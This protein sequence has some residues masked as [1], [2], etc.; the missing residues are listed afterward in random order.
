MATA[1]G[2]TVR[3]I[4]VLRAIAATAVVY[5][6]CNPPGGGYGFPQ[7]GAWGVDIFFVISGFIIART[8]FKRPEGFMRS[9]IIRVVPI[10]LV[11]TVLTAVAVA[12]FPHRIN[13]TEVSPDGLL[14]SALFIPYEMATRPGPILEAGWTLSYEMFFYV[15]VALAL[16]ATG[17]AKRGL[18][19]AAVLLFLLVLSGWVS[20]SGWYLV[21][22]YQS[23][24]F[25]EFLSGILLWAAYERSRVNQGVFAGGRTSGAVTGVIMIAVGFTLLVAADTWDLFSAGF[26]ERF[27][28]YGVPSVLV[29]VGGLLTEPALS[30][31]R[32]MRLLVE[33]GDA[34]YAL[35]LFHPFVI[36]FLSR[37]AFDSV[38]PG[39]GLGLRVVMLLLAIV[40]A[41]VASVVVNRCVDGPIQ[42]RLRR[43]LLG[44]TSSG[45]VMSRV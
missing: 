45:K 10:Y 18:T 30:A 22:F 17:S 7:T 6:H 2:G 23:S 5:F 29:V 19:V 14:K 36:L 31:G 33:L 38:L 13:S 1:S 37:I 44:S 21:R 11:A 20:P 43:R 24:L 12:A 28:Q 41:L 15:V 9:R 3:S 4:Q 34:S 39:A 16:L 8:A 32:W 27:V 26:D 25:L 35:Y 40:L 42:T